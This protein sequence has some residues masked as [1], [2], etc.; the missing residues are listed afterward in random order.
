MNSRE[1]WT[2]LRAGLKAGQ[3]QV[4]NVEWRDDV[5]APPFKLKGIWETQT[6]SGAR[7]CWRVSF[8]CHHRPITVETR[9]PRPK[10]WL[11]E[12]KAS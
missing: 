9:K 5:G 3:F 4:G 2:R 12:S 8:S 1:L 10:L 7:E 11:V 6:A